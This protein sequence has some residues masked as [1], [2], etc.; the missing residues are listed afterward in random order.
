MSNASLEDHLVHQMVV[1]EFHQKYLESAHALAML[2]LQSDL[3]RNPEV[4][5]EVDFMLEY[6]KMEREYR[7]K[8]LGIK[9]KE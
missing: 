1:R 3:Y 6:W 2:V 9:R 7:D 8:V 5:E 4:K